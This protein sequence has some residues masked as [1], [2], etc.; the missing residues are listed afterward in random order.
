MTFEAGDF[1]W[2]KIYQAADHVLLATSPTTI[3]HITN[4]HDGAGQLVEESWQNYHSE[5]RKKF[6][7]HEE[8][9]HV[10]RH[11]AYG[12]P[13]PV[14]T[15]LARAR[16]DIKALNGRTTYYSLLKCNCEHWVRSWIFGGGL[17]DQAFDSMSSECE[18]G[19]LSGKNDFI[20]VYLFA[21]AFWPM[22][23]VGLNFDLTVERHQCLNFAKGYAPTNR[24]AS[25]DNSLT[26][27]TFKKKGECLRLWRDSQC[28]GESVCVCENYA[29]LQN[30]PLGS[31]GNWN[32]EVTS[33]SFC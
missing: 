4:V 16:A 19:K 10:S 24:L 1:L 6:H 30:L 17:S 8:C 20:G 11:G 31:G 5:K 2:C 21:H 13:L 15:I 14:E 12:V 23:Y 22:T 29:N 26:R 7:G 33:M 28:T 9:R 25:F 3:A 18:V 32:N 27:I